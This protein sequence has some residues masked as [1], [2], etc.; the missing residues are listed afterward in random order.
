MPSR[1]AAAVMR[2]PDELLA[3]IAALSGARSAR[4]SGR[5]QSLWSGYGEA[6]R[7][8][9]EG[10]PAPTAVV[11]AVAPPPQAHPRKLRSYE[12]ERAWYSRHA[13]RCG[14]G[15]RVPACYGVWSDGRRS[16]FVLEDLDAAGFAGRAYALSDARIR[17]ALGWL[18]RFHAAFLG[19]P[20]EGLWPV[21]TYWHL[22]TRPDEL[23]AMRDRALRERAPALDA[24][25][26]AARFQTFVH[27]DAKAANFC[28]G[29]GEQV[30]AVDFQ[31]VGGGVGV[32]DVAYFLGGRLS[33]RRSL[34]EARWLDHYFA[35][36]RAALPPG[37]DAD[38][39]EAEWRGLYDVACLD[40]A[41]FLDG[42]R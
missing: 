36:L 22:A 1:Y 38:G 7:V 9:L 42:W 37:A 11:K 26:S 29:D 20:P 41:R 14:P 33:V 8:T 27:G 30:A 34:E 25:L 40:F 16:V 3:R 23:A 18:A 19:R 35:A 12:V 24:Q 39:V 13:A 32:K 6:F 5:I 17:A 2:S 10:G 21:G 31:Y 28:F 4:R 15:C